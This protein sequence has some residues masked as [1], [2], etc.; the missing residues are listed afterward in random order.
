MAVTLSANYHDPSG[1]RGAG[2]TGWGGV[3]PCASRALPNFW[4]GKRPRPNLLPTY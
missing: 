2:L 1:S 3:L 4:F